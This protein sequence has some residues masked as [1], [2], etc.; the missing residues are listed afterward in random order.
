MKHFS[1]L[2][3]FF[4]VAVNVA[5]GRISSDEA[6][7][8]FIDSLV[9]K[10][11]PL[12]DFIQETTVQLQSLSSSILSL[13]Q[14]LSQ[15]Q[16]KP[17]FPRSCKDFVKQSLRM[18]GSGV[19]DILLNGVLTQVYCDMETQGGGWTYVARGTP[20]VT[21][22]QLGE[23]Q[24]NPSADVIWHFSVDDINALKD[25]SEDYLES[26]ITMAANCRDNYVLDCPSCTMEVGNYRV[27]LEAGNFSFTTPMDNYTAW[28]GTAY[29]TVS[30]RPCIS[31]DNG[32]CWEPDK[33]RQP[34][35]FRTN[36][37]K[38]IR[39]LTFAVSWTPPPTALAPVRLP[40]RTMRVSSAI[41]TATN[42][43]AVM[44]TRS[45]AMGSSSSCG[46]PGAALCPAE[47]KQNVTASYR[48]LPQAVC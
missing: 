46:S 48:D 16:K 18:H 43:S 35:S 30:S 12:K 33:K 15:C 45:Q 20:G 23:I 31:D 5:F 32:P 13:Q 42:I 29:A 36:Y 2:L 44:S 25:P 6:N 39:L 11:T 1:L 22:L 3:F 14:E 9:V 28:N 8:V 21:D 40:R 26:Y 24:I 4:L 34:F 27:R 10:G 38:E 41:P 37:G 19:Y 17:V 47:K 7:T